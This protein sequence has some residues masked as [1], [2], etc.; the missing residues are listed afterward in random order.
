MRKRP[1]DDHDT[2][3]KEMARRYFRLLL[4]FFFPLLAVQIDWERGIEFLD[5]ELKQAVR[6]AG[7]G[8]R[9][10]DMLARVWLKNGALACVLAHLEIQSQVDRTLPERMYL[11]R[12]LLHA[13]E[14][15]KVASLCILADPDFHWRPDRYE[16]EVLGSELTL[17]YPVVKLLDYRSRWEELRQDPNPFALVVMAHLRSLETKRSP[18]QR[19]QWKTELMVLMHERGYSDDQVQDLYRFLDLV[20]PLPDSLQFEYEKEVVRYEEEHTMPVITQSE[21][22]AIERGMRKGLE[23]GLEQGVVQ[24][25]RETV[26]DAL[27]ERFPDAPGVVRARV[28]EMADAAALR[29]L[30]RAIMRASSVQEIEQYLR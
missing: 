24:G 4:E 12:C 19:L 22:H 13:R 20:M 27:D 28:S 23:Q 26:L 29:S 25:V 8:G 2:G 21:R 16:D 1:A 10:V 17:K 14:R 9:A 5:K 30:H 3:W 7:R 15:L 18:G 6:L 11:Y